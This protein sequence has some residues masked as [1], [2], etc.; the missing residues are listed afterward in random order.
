MQIIYILSLSLNNLFDFQLLV[1]KDKIC[2]I[3]LITDISPLIYIYIFPKFPYFI[4]FF[5]QRRQS[6]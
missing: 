5:L 3:L 1:F 6:Q 2:F 4:I